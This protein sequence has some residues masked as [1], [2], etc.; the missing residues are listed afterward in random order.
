MT[1]VVKFCGIDIS[2]DSFD[3]AVANAG[4]CRSKKFAY[5]RQGMASLLEWLPAEVH[6]VM[7]ST[8]TYHL[9]A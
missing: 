5:D 4:D 2:K 1:K 6:C 8:G 3:V 7:E 9:R